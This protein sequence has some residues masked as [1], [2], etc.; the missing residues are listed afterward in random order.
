MTGDSNAWGV[1]R[2]LWVFGYGSLIW[3]PG[4]A[5]AEQ[6][7]AVLDGFHRSFCMWSIHHRGSAEAPGLV[8]AL[9]EEPAAQ[10]HGVAF[11]VAAEECA[12][13]LAYL[14][15]RELISSAYEERE[16]EIAL[17]TGQR[18]AAVAYVIDPTHTQYC[19]GL[20]LERQ[21]EVIAHAHGGRGANDVYLYQTVEHLDALGIPCPDLAQLAALVRKIKNA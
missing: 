2:D 14:R 6:Q 21:A 16:V 9:D 15:E 1:T 10:C 8:L 13:A 5:Y 7:G 3:N 11:R 4:F 17:A 19:R 20:S 12:A 18:V